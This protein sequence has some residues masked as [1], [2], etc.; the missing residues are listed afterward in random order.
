MAAAA[1]VTLAGACLTDPATYGTSATGSS[2]GSGETSSQG[3]TSSDAASS[4]GAGGA[5]SSTTSGTTEASSSAS[6]GSTTA[7]TGGAGGGVPTTMPQ[8]V[9]ALA[10]NDLKEQ[11]LA[12]LVVDP[13]GNTYI[14]GTWEGTND[15]NDVPW[16]H[17]C[18]GLTTFH[19][20]VAK[21]SPTG[22]VL[23]GDCLAT[24]NASG[25]AI[26]YESSSHTVV[27]GG[28]YTGTLNGFPT[29]D[30]TSMGGTD[31][32]VA[33]LSHMGTRVS[34]VSLG[35]P[36]DDEVTGVVALP[37]DAFVAG[38]FQGTAAFG[39]IMRT[40]QS[41]A[42]VFVAR[43]MGTGFAFARAYVET[44]SAPTAHLSGAAATLRLAGTFDGTLDFGGS[45]SALATSGGR[46]AYLAALDATG[47]A[48]FARA[49]GGAGDD[50][51]DA[52]GW[53]ANG[54]ALGGEFAATL[55]FDG[56]GG[57]PGL[58]AAEPPD[59]FLVELQP[60]LALD[61]QHR[62]GGAGTQRTL[63]VSARGTTVVAGGTFTGTVGFGGL[64]QTAEDEDGFA[65]KGDVQGGIDWVVRLGQSGDQRVTAA[66]HTFGVSGGL[67]VFGGTMIDGFSIFGQ[68]LGKTG[69]T[70]RD[71]FLVAFQD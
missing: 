29:G 46:D 34:I 68:V 33:R 26:S 69:S 22:G 1:L 58:A 64:D 11:D 42:D 39:S 27:V 28:R 56:P 62:F 70:T 20:F 61:T 54:L 2:S 31:G 43:T 38:T 48:T 50:G 44:A 13:D 32:F 6:A 41:G 55:D 5:T 65:L 47:N 7:G 66:D 45:T 8:K 10:I 57:Q 24:A 52:V 9:W 25:L 53:S 21:L 19:A 23:W 30:I 12:A 63:G 35:G 4:S 16:L 67:N 49:F 59:G 3:S 17:G 14:T 36:L 40:A 18:V 71:I 51:V 60:T 15:I 37:N